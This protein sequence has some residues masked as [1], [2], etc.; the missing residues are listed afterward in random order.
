[1]EIFEATEDNYGGVTVNMKREELIDSHKFHTM[2]MTSISHWRQKGKKAVWIKLP[3]ELAHLV[4]A[5]VKEEFWYHHAE[6]T[7]LMLVYWIPETPQTLPANA[8]HRV[9]IGALVLNNNGQVLVVKEKSGK[10]TGIWK[11][12]TGVVEEG[13]DICMAAIREVQEE[14]GIETEFIEI[15]AFRQSHKSF[16]G[17]SDLFFI[18]IL[19]PLNFTIRK[20]NAEIE[21]A[22]WMAIEE[23]AA[24]PKLNKSELSKN[25]AKICLAKKD[26]EYTGFSAVITTTGLSAKNCYLYCNI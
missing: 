13:E 1:M 6:A 26:N 14:T 18:C 24:Q 16:F 4:E 11:L 12:P 25:I 9:G 23:Y 7:Y 15:L 5:A 3:I 19:K 17:K 21:E 20:Q 10:S 8:S 22:Q 2:L